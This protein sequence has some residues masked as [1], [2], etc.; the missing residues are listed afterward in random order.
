MVKLIRSSSLAAAASLLLLPAM[1]CEESG[2][3]VQEG[4]TSTSP[5]PGSSAPGGASNTPKGA[6]SSGAAPGVV[7]SGKLRQECE[8]SSGCE[9]AKGYRLDSGTNATC[10][11]RLESAGCRKA[12]GEKVQSFAKSPVGETW[13]FADGK[14]PDG[15]E[16]L[17]ASVVGA[18][19]PTVA[20][21][22]A[23]D[24]HLKQCDGRDPK[25]CGY[26][27]MAASGTRYDASK[28]C[29]FKKA[30]AG[31]FYPTFTPDPNGSSGVNCSM[32]TQFLTDP[33]GQTYYFPNTCAPNW[34][35]TPGDTAKATAIISGSKMCE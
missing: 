5:L 29:K 33:S 19:L 28:E 27:C 6:N 21:R 7:C 31:C 17:D 18:S 8:S 4:V 13:V 1:G 2:P 30:P 12:S 23:S 9:V 10:K 11:Y 22:V 15:W 3:D 20:C 16:V 35:A 32:M 25:D 34:T 26:G 14:G 24:P